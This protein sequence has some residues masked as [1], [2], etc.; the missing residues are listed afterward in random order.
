MT[1]AEAD[2]SLSS[3]TLASESRSFGEIG[4]CVHL[5]SNQCS[6]FAIIWRYLDRRL[7]YRG[8]GLPARV[9]S[10]ALASSRNL[11]RRAG[12]MNAFA[13]ADSCSTESIDIRGHRPTILFRRTHLGGAPPTAGL[14]ELVD[15]AEGVAECSVPAERS[16][17]GLRVEKP[18]ALR[19]ELG[20]GLV[21]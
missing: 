8:L 15:C 20:H 9:V 19:R 1:Y 12:R 10:R 3:L 6:R 7:K 13:I 18:H 16:F 21:Q 5:G 17:G 14:S 11:P 2:A 4:S